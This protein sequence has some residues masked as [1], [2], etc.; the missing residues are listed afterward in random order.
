MEKLADI[1][2][3]ERNYEWHVAK[4]NAKIIGQPLVTQELLW[5]VA[6]QARDIS[7]SLESKVRLLEKIH[8]FGDDS[9]AGLRLLEKDLNTTVMQELGETPEPNP[10]L[11]RYIKYL[12]DYDYGKPAEENEYKK[13]FALRLTRIVLEEFVSK[14]RTNEEWLSKEDIIHTYMWDQSRVNEFSFGYNTHEGD[15]VRSYN[16][17]WQV[18]D[19]IEEQVTEQWTKLAEELLGESTHLINKRMLRWRW[20]PYVETV[21]E[22]FLPVVNKA[23]SKAF[24][25][26]IGD[27]LRGVKK[28]DLDGGV[29]N[30]DVVESVD[31]IDFLKWMLDDVE[32]L[33]KHHKDIAANLRR[34][35]KRTVAKEGRRLPKIFS[36]NIRDL[37]T[38]VDSKRRK[39]WPLEW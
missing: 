18:R 22:L 11:T 3:K 31:R 30:W 4:G 15:V 19:F 1:H 26:E 13:K 10:F 23:V 32:G 6:S 37:R 24:K 14:E 36:Q 16:L 38:L 39:K 5:S 2:G 17:G 34:I 25:L 20:H 21:L 28:D 35:I 8:G 7:I 33:A 29:W 12:N 27:N 9:Y